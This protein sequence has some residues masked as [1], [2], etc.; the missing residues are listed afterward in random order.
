MVKPTNESLP[1]DVHVRVP[2]RVVQIPVRQPGIR[3][4]VPVPADE[5]KRASHIPKL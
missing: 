1:A 3:A 4:V 5:G 2:R